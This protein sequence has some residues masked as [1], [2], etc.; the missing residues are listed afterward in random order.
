MIPLII[1]EFRKDPVKA[2]AITLAVGVVGYLLV[3]KGFKGLTAGITGKSALPQ[4]PTYQQITNPDGSKAT[5]TVWSPNPLAVALF[6]QMQGVSW[7]G[8]TAEVL[9][10]LEAQDPARIIAVYNEYNKIAQKKGTGET[11]TQAINDEWVLDAVKDRVLAKL[12]SLG[13]G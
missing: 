9:A 12:E 10:K 5:V 8:N 11:L 4:A 7:G 3:K 1:N 6:N 13:L 2:G